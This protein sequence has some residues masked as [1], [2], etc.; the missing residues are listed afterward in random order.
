MTE[1]KLFREAIGNKVLQEVLKQIYL[2]PDSEQ[3]T[4]RLR[5]ARLGA[6]MAGFDILNDE[7]LAQVR[8]ATGDDLAI[9]LGNYKGEIPT[10]GHF[11]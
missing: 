2:E 11:G 7:I 6:I 1:N 3:L 9:I 5:M 10:V 4:R 8:N